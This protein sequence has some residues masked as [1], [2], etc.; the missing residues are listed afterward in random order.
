[1]HR[2]GAPRPRLTSFLLP[3]PPPPVQP[4]ISHGR[5]RP[6]A[7]HRP[8]PV[9]TGA[10]ATRKLQNRRR[11]ALGPPPPSSSG[12]GGT[13]LP[14]PTP[15]PTPGLA[16]F[17]VSRVENGGGGVCAVLQN[18]AEHCRP[19]KR[20]EDG[21]QEWRGCMGG[22]PPVDGCLR[23]CTFHMCGRCASRTNDERL[24]SQP[25]PAEWMAATPP[26]H[27]LSSV[28]H[29]RGGLAVRS[30][31]TAPIFTHLAC[32]AGDICERR[33]GTRLGGACGLSAR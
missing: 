32:A 9:A 22:V 26:S 25:Y 10:V 1:M 7:P 14:S 19:S 17:P 3:L 5:L 33:M 31:Q 6:A 13:R 11:S 29:C 23:S 20:K 21:S 24:V 16:G 15:P 4:G 8:N 27:H 30:V 18:P 12:V 2:S 28:L